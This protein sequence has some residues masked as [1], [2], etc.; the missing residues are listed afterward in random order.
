MF[1]RE[2]KKQLNTLFFQRFTEH[3]SSHRSIGGGGK[4]WEAY[5]TGVKGVYFRMLTLPKV[6]LAIDV[7]AK[8][9]E[10]RVLIYDQFLELR[11]LLEAEWGE[12]VVYESE[13]AYAS[14]EAISRIAV[15]L[16]DAYFFDQ[17]QWP[18]ILNWY[19]EKWIALDQFWET[20]GD[21]VK[22]LAR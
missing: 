13:T 11:R 2:E 3:M 1:S 20:T 19:Q 8:D 15:Y 21:I 7:Q 12:G 22:A 9:D 18:T 4:K 6:G 17:K 5:K 14:G 16:E 10:I